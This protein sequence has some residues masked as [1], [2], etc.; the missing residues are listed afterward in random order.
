[1]ATK[2]SMKRFLVTAF[3]VAALPAFQALA[4]EGPE[5]IRIGV[6]RLSPFLNL[7]YLYDS[8]PNNANDGR[9]DDFERVDAS[10]EDADVK[11][12]KSSGYTI[13]P[14]IN[15][16]LPG[17]NWKLV[18][19]AYFL[20]DHYM[21]GTEDDHKDWSESL[22][23][24][25]E[26]DGGLRYKISEEIRKAQYSEDFKDNIGNSMEFRD[27]Q[28][29]IEELGD[30]D[31]DRTYQNYSFSLAKSLTEKSDIELSGTYSDTD[32]DDDSLF[33]SC[34]YGGTLGFTLKLTEKS[35]G[36]I[37]SSYIIH[38]EDENDSTSDAN[39][40]HKN[41]YATSKSKSIRG[42]IGLRSRATEK[43]TYDVGVGVEHYKDFEDEMGDSDSETGFYYDANITWKATPRL[44][45]SLV[46]DSSFQ[47]AEDVGS[48]SEQ[49]SSIGLNANYRP[50]ERWKF[51][52][53]IAYR[54]E[55]YT[56]KLS[57]D[58]A[59][60]FYTD[61]K[62][63]NAKDR[64]DDGIATFFRAVYGICEYA[65]VFGDVRYTDISSSIDEYDYDRY[66][67]SIGMALRY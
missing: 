21:D 17:N 56:R 25:G 63:K 64:K 54:V 39:R 47:P 59:D 12:E 65:S 62:G 35:D 9:K 5:G 66:R 13:Q 40:T 10:I 27:L 6:A 60:N 3:A 41:A 48:N 58:E 67:L 38:E 29:L 14:G 18:G 24:S 52:C 23:F 36:F 50:F 53:G 43:V 20:L 16:T 30:Q 61:D 34:S 19:S 7:S 33:D 42:L 37:R 57:E 31:S 15:L 28:K 8:N 1:M 55:D 4:D 49:S 51:S 11:I 46:G 22:T 44:T 2:E 45:I 26:T 32:Y